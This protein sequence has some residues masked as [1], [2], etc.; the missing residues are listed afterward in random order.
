MD[1]YETYYP[2]CEENTK[3][4]YHDTALGAENTNLVYTTP[5]NSI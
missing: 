3:S 4:L 1:I 2:E 5:T